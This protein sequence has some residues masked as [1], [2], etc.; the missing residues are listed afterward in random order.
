MKKTDGLVSFTLLPIFL[1]VAAAYYKSMWLVPVVVIVMFVLVGVL[2]FTYGHENLWIFV[3]TA[4]CSLPINW[5]LVKKYDFW[6]IYF[7]ESTRD[8]SYRLMFLEMV[9][10]PVGLEEIAAGLLA[11]FIWRK[12][13]ALYLP[14]NDGDG[15]E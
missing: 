14:V 5:M 10:I 2:P 8:V 7:F 15:E 9:L 13:Y 6:M 3:L 4:L 12:Q 1:S 11:R